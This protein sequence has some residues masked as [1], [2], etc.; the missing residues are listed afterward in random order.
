M[1]LGGI[2]KSSMYMLLS[3][4]HSIIACA[5]YQV[6]RMKWAL[7]G[8]KKPDD[9]AVALVRE[10]VTFI[11]KSFERQKLAK[12]LYHNIQAYYPGVKVIIADDSRKPLDLKADHLEII[13]LPFNSGLSY[14]LNRALERVETPYVIRMDDDQLLT[15]YTR[16]DEQL[17][18]LMA[19]PKVDLVGVLQYSTPKLVPLRSVAKE[20]YGQPMDFSPRRL[21][22]PHMTQ[23]DG[24]VVVGKGSNVFV[25]STQK[26]R[27][28]GYDDQIRMLDHQEFFYR[29]AGRLVSVIDPKAFVFH[30]HNRFKAHYR[31]YRHDIDRDRCYITHKIRYDQLQTMKQY[32]AMNKHESNGGNNI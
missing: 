3:A 18:Y 13:Q 27:E 23:I 21:L 31:S 17:H 26:L 32:A 24:R 1:R 9:E 30:N 11:Y 2:A 4:A 19:H 15:P 5:E 6:L 8:A 22:I 25:V 16:F 29:A 12:K 20:F 7:A 10:N 28:I 14:G